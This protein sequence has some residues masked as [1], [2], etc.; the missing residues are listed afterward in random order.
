[1]RDTSDMATQTDESSP[2]SIKDGNTPSR[3]VA[4]QTLSS[5]HSTKAKDLCQT[6]CRL[7]KE[8]IMKVHEDLAKKWQKL[9]ELGILKALG[10]EDN[11]EEEA[12]EADIKALVSSVS[13]TNQS[14]MTACQI[15]ANSGLMGDVT[16]LSSEASSEAQSATSILIESS[17]S[18]ASAPC[19]TGSSLASPSTSSQAPDAS[20]TAEPGP[21]SQDMR[22]GLT[23]SLPSTTVPATPTSPCGSITSMASPAAAAGDVA[24][25]DMEEMRRRVWEPQTPQTP[26][27]IRAKILYNVDGFQVMSNVPASHR[28]ASSTH[29]PADSR[30][31]FSAI[32]K[33]VSRISCTHSLQLLIY[34]S[35]TI[36]RPFDVF[37]TYQ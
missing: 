2:E 36:F 19:I 29:Q 18:S 30:A 23:L 20:V 12:T 9:R 32:K 1:M 34:K 25:P 11:D 17:L 21:S 22:S 14:A 24:S 31:F 5:S 16:G 13:K 4:V 37:Y 35:L 33:E 3:E 26:A 27:E 10:H 15:I 28:F 6:A 8:Q 7:L